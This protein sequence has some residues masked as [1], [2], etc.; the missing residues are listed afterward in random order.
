M[1]FRTQISLSK[2]LTTSVNKNIKH[3]SSSFD[4][5]FR[6]I[7][8]QHNSKCSAG[9][10]SNPGWNF[11]CF[12]NGR[13]AVPAAVA[14]DVAANDKYAVVDTETFM[15][16]PSRRPRKHF[17][18]S[19]RVFVYSQV[20]NHDSGRKRVSSTACFPRTERASIARLPATKIP[21]ILPVDLDGL[22]G[23]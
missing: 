8:T 18:A 17:H 14:A 11:S 1:R 5:L 9:A 7:I 13:D 16:P 10:S 20:I 15:R 6:E 4:E 19:T 21:G 22:I 23:G 3:L 12:S 2:T